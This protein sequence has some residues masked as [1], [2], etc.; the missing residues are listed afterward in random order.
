[1][2]TTD[3]LQIRTIALRNLDPRPDYLFA[4]RLTRKVGGK[5]CHELMSTPG[6][7]LNKVTAI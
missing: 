7:K 6:W 5:S 1:M 4:G 2:V 3:C